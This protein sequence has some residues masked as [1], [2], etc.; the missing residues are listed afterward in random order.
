MIEQ[1]LKVDVDKYE[2]NSW[3]KTA[4]LPSPPWPC[5]KMSQPYNV[6]SR[7][8]VL[9][10]RAVAE[11]VKFGEWYGGDGE[12]GW[13]GGHLSPDREGGVVCAIILLWASIIS[14]WEW[15]E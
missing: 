12:G 13:G 1:S 8:P 14:S 11:L 10:L 6:S 3:H 5:A 4:P 7:A 15:M 2:A 9:L